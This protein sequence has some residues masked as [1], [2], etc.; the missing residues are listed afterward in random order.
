ML[1]VAIA[2]DYGQT[3]HPLTE[4]EEEE[5]GKGETF[6]WLRVQNCQFMFSSLPFSHRMNCLAGQKKWT[7]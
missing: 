3:S 5:F 6:I 4:A 7:D 2:N 1:I